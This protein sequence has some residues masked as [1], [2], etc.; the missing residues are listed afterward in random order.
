M[1]IEGVMS[2]PQTLVPSGVQALSSICSKTL[3][4][5]EQSQLDIA[6]DWLFAAVA[7]GSRELLRSVSACLPKAWL[8]RLNWQKL[9]EEAWKGLQSL[10]DRDSSAA[11]ADW[12]VAVAHL[13]QI[14]P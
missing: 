4:F 12:F 9:A 8:R 2:L 7:S 10:W 5:P 14:M 11:A 3:K 1:L 6:R 13:H